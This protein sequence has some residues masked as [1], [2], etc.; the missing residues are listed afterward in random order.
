MVGGLEKKQFKQR[1]VNSDLEI[2]YLAL[3]Q[4][5]KPHNLLRSLPDLLIC[6]A[7]LNLS[8]RLDNLGE[9]TLGVLN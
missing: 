3:G 4:E 6:N 1:S 2:V 8:R 5:N 7:V 9:N